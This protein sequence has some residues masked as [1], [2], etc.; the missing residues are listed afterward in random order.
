MMASPSLT[1]AVPG[2]YQ[3]LIITVSLKIVRP[4][5]LKK[6]VSDCMKVAVPEMVLM[7][8]WYVMKGRRF[9]SLELLARGFS[10]GWTM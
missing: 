2:Q 6:I 3:Q 5:V 7:T 9:S 8:K 10:I 1:K 4:E